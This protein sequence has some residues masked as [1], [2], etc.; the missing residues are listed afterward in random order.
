MLRVDAGVTGPWKHFGGDQNQTAEDD[1]QRQDVHPWQAG[2][3]GGIRYPESTDDNDGFNAKIAH[4]SGPALTLIGPE[5]ERNAEGENKN[6]SRAN[7][8]HGRTLLG[9]FL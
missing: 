8:D 1:Q 5:C 3:P 4:E 9:A 2:A 6:Q 7:G